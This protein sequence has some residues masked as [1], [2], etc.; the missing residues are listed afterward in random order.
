MIRIIII[1]KS[2]KLNVHEKNK[3]LCSAIITMA[4]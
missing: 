1:M 4:I 3:G 2:M